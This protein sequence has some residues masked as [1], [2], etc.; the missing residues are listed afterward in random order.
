MIGAVFLGF[1]LGAII[2]SPK[3]AS[4][5]KTPTNKTT[6]RDPLPGV[7]KEK[8]SVFCRLMAC[9]PTGFKAPSGKLGAFAFSPRRLVDMGLASRAQRTQ[10]VWEAT[11]AKPFTEMAF[12]K[13]PK[14]QYAVFC[15]SNR[16]YLPAAIAA[17]GKPVGDKII[18]VSGALA[19]LHLAGEAGFGTWVSDSKI[20]SRFSN[21]TKAFQSCNGV[22]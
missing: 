3:K 12:L 20:R 14:V 7:P 6:L 2:A 8:W 17:R 21:T 4:H 18:T 9:S 16:C 15:K 5:A 1:A 11:F 13:S 19:V 10:A 22:F